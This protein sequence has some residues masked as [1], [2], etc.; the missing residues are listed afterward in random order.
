MD[1]SL[2]VTSLIIIISIIIAYYLISSL[3]FDS[4]FITLQG[5]MTDAKK[6]QTISEYDIGEI[7][8]GQNY[9]LSWWMYIDDFNYRN[10]QEK[11]ILQRGNSFRVK[12]APNRATIV[13]ETEEIGNDGLVSDS[14][15]KRC[16]VDNI[17]LQRWVFCTIVVSTKY[18]DIYYN[19]KLA[20]SCVYNNPTK[21]YAGD[22]LVTPNVNGEDA[23]F[24]GYMSRI[25]FSKKPA[26]SE[27][28][29][30]KYKNGP[31]KKS[32]FGLLFGIDE[33]NIK[34]RN[35]GGSKSTFNVAF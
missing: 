4:N 25:E 26:T 13:V 9:T 24:S 8:Q 14:N 16:V 10:G 15:I 35:I 34:Y 22:L 17:D 33:I 20:R 18:I 5:S 19:G 32:I 11:V 6:Q 29:F 28:I 27:E 23:G 30:N 12:L 1:Y 7:N 31:I 2:I 3:F 21:Q